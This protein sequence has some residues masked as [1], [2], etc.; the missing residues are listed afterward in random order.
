MLG[1]SSAEA[2]QLL[3]TSVPSINSALQRAR[4]TLESRYT[5]DRPITPPAPTDTHRALLE[6]YVRTWEAADLDGFVALLREDAV[7]S[8]PPFREWYAGREAIRCFFCP[9]GGNRTFGVSTIEPL[10]YTP[11]NR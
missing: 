4:A 9:G 7:L 11:R 10:S 6:R 8:M 2:A 1:W 5:A 3:D